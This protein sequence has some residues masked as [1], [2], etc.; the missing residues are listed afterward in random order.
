[1]L[2]ATCQFAIA[3][4]QTSEECVEVASCHTVT[5]T[6]DGAEVGEM[7][8][9]QIL[10]HVILEVEGAQRLVGREVELCKLV[11]THA[12]VL[13][14]LVLFHVECAEVVV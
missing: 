3:L 7:L 11:A 2:R 6:V 10:Y 12:K 9:V 1:M 4:G 14:H 13:E 5:T 8:Q